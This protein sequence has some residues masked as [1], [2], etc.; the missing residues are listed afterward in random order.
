MMVSILNNRI[1]SAVSDPDKVF[2]DFAEGRISRQKAMYRL[3]IE[4]GQLLDGLAER[5][6]HI[7]RP[8]EAEVE[9]GAIDMLVF[10]GRRSA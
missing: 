4:Y 10:L 8:E 6:L 3:D 2:T 5:K 1:K 7:P 9:K